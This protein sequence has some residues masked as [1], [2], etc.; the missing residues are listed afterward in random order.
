M[1]LRCMVEGGRLACSV[2]WLRGTQTSK[3]KKTSPPIFDNLTITVSRSVT[4]AS[5]TAII[6]FITIRHSYLYYSELLYFSET[7]LFPSSPCLLPV[8]SMRRKTLNPC[9]QAQKMSL[10]AEAGTTKYGS[11]LNMP[12]NLPYTKT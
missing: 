7:L 2:L 4:F 8:S 5:I 1:I 12:C 3:G 10:D 9:L 11:K 6:T